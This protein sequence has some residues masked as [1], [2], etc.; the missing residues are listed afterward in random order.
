MLKKAVFALSG[1]GER[2]NLLSEAG[3]CGF[4]TQQ[5]VAGF[6]S[7]VREFVEHVLDSLYAPFHSSLRLVT[8]GGGDMRLKWT[9]VSMDHADRHV[10]WRYICDV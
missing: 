7:C 9:N 2:V 4:P 5:G 3:E 1:N 6:R 8:L 10:N